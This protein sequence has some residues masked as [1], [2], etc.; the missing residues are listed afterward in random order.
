MLTYRQLPSYT[1]MKIT[2]LNLQFIPLQD[3]MLL[4][5][6]TADGE[7]MQFWITRRYLAALW[8]ML[9][10][11]VA[12]D[13]DV[14]RQDIPASRR[15]VLAFKQQKTLAQVDTTKKFDD[16]PAHSHPLGEQPLLL[17]R[18]AIRNRDD[19]APSLWLADRQDKGLELTLTESLPHLLL[20]LVTETHRQS[21]WQLPDILGYARETRA[22]PATAAAPN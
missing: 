2:Q 11:V 13:G 16:T 19:R 6:N 22:D 3:R 8:T 10:K 15:S 1:A 18:V 12:A 5:M 14:A 21:D 20:H 17:S 9:M 7:R 4:R